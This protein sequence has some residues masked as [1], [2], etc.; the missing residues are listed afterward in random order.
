LR[1][2]VLPKAKKTPE[3]LAGHRAAQLRDGAA[4]VEFLAW[5]DRSDTASMTEIDVAT[6]L[7]GFRKATGALRDISFETIC[8]AGPNGAIVH[9]RVNTDTNRTLGEDTLLLVDSG[10]Q[11]LDG[12]TDITRT[13]AL[14][15]APEG[16]VKAFTLVLS[17]M[18]ALS[19][20]RWPDGLTGRDIEM[21]S[22]ETLTYVPIDRRMIDA[23]LLSAADRAWLNAY[24]AE[25]AKRLE[26]EV[27]RDAALWLKQ[28]TAPI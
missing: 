9:Y 28:A 12:T 24:H 20:Q 23:S 25:T 19:R 10:G 7:E 16:S 5:L 11:Y 22:F 1:L 13:I 26:R 3:E 6:R 2:I 14:G 27:S 15:T 18:I 4:M 8:G 17:G 21:L